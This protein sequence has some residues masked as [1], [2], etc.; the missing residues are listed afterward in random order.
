MRPRDAGLRG[1]GLH[2]PC[3]TLRR[4]N[5][6]SWTWDLCHMYWMDMMP[7][8]SPSL[9]DPG[10]IRVSAADLA[11][12][13]ELNALGMQMVRALAPRVERD[14]AAG[15]PGEAA[16]VMR[17]FMLTVQRG[18]ALKGKWAR[19]ARLAE[20]ETSGAG[21][22]FRRAPNHERKPR[23]KQLVMRAITDMKAGPMKTAR[24]MRALETRLDCLDLGAELGDR[25]LGMIAIDLCN[26]LNVPLGKCIYTDAEMA[27]TKAHLERRIAN[28]DEMEAEMEMRAAKAAARERARRGHASP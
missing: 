11:M 7:P 17:G 16:E 18:L 20:R 14:V 6:L 23:L 9:P 26:G 2:F 13:D 1:V 8:P 10:G 5:F 4:R 19:D 3:S 22:A 25:P 12:L 28:E 24:L 15:A 27:E 21:R